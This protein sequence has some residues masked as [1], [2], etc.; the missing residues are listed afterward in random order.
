[1]KLTTFWRYSGGV[2]AKSAWTTLRK[3]RTEG[4]AAEGDPRPSGC[5]ASLDGMHQHLG[6]GSHESCMPPSCA[7][8]GVRA[9]L[10]EATDQPACLVS[11]SGTSTTAGDPAPPA[12]RDGVWQPTSDERGQRPSPAVLVGW[13]D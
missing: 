9:S 2:Y 10:N 11:V 8:T 3:L 5:C 4:M 13:R 7:Y 1:I 6:T 12:K